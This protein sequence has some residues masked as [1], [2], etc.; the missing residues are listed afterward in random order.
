[1][2]EMTEMTEENRSSGLSYVSDSNPRASDMTV[3]ST[4]GAWDPENAT[5]D[6]G[7]LP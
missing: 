2:T 6:D 4:N 5:D 7:E 1:M 3:E